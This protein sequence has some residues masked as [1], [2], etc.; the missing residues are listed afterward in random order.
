[1]AARRAALLSPISKTWYR[2]HLIPVN[3]F[4]AARAIFLKEKPS[5]LVVGRAS[6]CP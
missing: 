5:P 2:F 1:M 4:F 3:N 6:G